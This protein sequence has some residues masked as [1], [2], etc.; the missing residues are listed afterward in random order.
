MAAPGAEIREPETSGFHYKPCRTTLR[1]ICIYYCD[2]F[3]LIMK[4]PQ[5][6]QPF[7]VPNTGSRTTH[8]LYEELLESESSKDPLV[9][10]WLCA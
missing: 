2:F 4:N 7:N 3:F 8:G 5:S 6:M 1:N 9:F 10:G